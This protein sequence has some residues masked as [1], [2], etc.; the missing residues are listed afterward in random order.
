[1]NLNLV[2]IIYIFSHNKL[3]PEENNKLVKI[4]KDLNKEYLF[5]SSGISMK[6][7][8]FKELEKELEK[9]K[10]DRL[11]FPDLPGIDANDE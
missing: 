1:M 5:Y 3:T 4:I 10:L 7:N 11:D 6:E 8:I 9:Y 2:D